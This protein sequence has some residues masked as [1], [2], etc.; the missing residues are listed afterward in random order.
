MNKTYEEYASDR[1]RY[2]NEIVIAVKNNAKKIVIAA[3]PGTG[4]TFLFLKIIK[5]KIEEIR[6]QRKKILVTT[7]INALVD[8]LSL[9]FYKFRDTVEVST[10]HSF[11]LKE[12]KSNATIDPDLPLVIAE[13]YLIFQNQP[14]SDK[15]NA[16]KRNEI[17]NMFETMDIKDDKNSEILDFYNKRRVFY[18]RTSFNSAIFDLVE[19]FENNL[20]NVPNYYKMVIVDEFQDFC[21][22]EERLLQCLGQVPDCQLILAGDDDQIVYEKATPEFLRIAYSPQENTFK[23]FTLPY[24]S[25]CTKCIVSFANLIISTAKDVGLLENRID[26]GYVYFKEKEKDKVSEEYKQISVYKNIFEKQIPF[27][28][29]KILHDVCDSDLFDKDSDVMIISPSYRIKS[30][31]N[32]LTKKGFKNIKIKDREKENKLLYGLRILLEAKNQSDNIGWRILVKESFSEDEFK[33]II[34]KSI[35]QD[36]KIEDIVGEEFK[37]KVK[38]VLTVLKKLRDE[39]LSNLNVEELTAVNNFLKSSEQHLIF[40]GDFIKNQNFQ[41]NS[42]PLKNIPITIT[43][44]QSSKG[45]S[46][47]FVFITHFDK[48]YIFKERTDKEVCSFLVSVTRAK[49][50]LYLINTD[51]DPPF[52]S[53]MD[54]DLF[55]IEEGRFS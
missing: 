8:D 43:T 28:I 45:L 39:G 10:L 11:A 26:K 27:Y 35:N 33:E 42:N 37:K 54:G 9:K 5:E 49:K 41:P 47:D 19:Y 15:K 24:C 23:S 55:K 25:R 46:A 13:D 30:I 7:F 2:T 53:D 50:K 52:I 48:Q 17:E 1:E 6:G 40:V 21:K 12:L 20:S 32:L 14:S 31:Y 34:L 4:K 36:K 18:N 16:E 51:G 38:S 3:G 22:L 44:A 29:D